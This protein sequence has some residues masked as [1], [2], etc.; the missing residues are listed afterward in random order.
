M[1][2]AARGRGAGS[3]SG[4]GNGYGN[5]NSQFRNLE[6]NFSTEGPIILSDT[7]GVDFGPYLS[8]IVFIVRRN[9]YSMIPESARLGEKGRVSIV[10]EILKDGSVPQIRLVAGSWLRSAGP[11][12]FGQHPRFGSLPTFARGV[13]RPSSRSSVYLPVQHDCGAAVGTGRGGAVKESPS[14]PINSAACHPERQ[15]RICICS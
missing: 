1:Q 10:F 12:S 9:W 11:R 6:P 13:Y 7:R 2:S 8:R 5:G 14:P 4:E 15:R 3:G